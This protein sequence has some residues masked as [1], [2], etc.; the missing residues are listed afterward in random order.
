MRPWSRPHTFWPAAQTATAVIAAGGQKA[1]PA[2]RLQAGP[3][4]GSGRA[5]TLPV[6]VGMPETVAAGTATSASLSPPAVTR[7]SVNMASHSASDALGM[8]GV[9][10]SLARSDGSLAAGRVHVSL[11]YSSFAQAAGGN[12]ASRLHLVELPP[13]ALTTPQLA[14]CRKQTPV[15]SADNVRTTR[16]GADVNLPGLA[17]S[18]TSRG[19]QAA[20]TLA[21]SVSPA[22]LVLAAIASTSGSGGNFAVEPLSEA[23]S[24]VT[25]SSSGA[26]RHSY[27]IQV[28][29]VPGGLEPEVSLDYD[30]QATDG[31]T[32]ST[33]N[34]ASW[35]GDGWDYS[36]GFIQVN[37]P[38]CSTTGVG[39]APG[40]L[41]EGA[42]QISLSL[43]GVTTP[44][45]ESSSGVWKVETDGGGEVLNQGTYWEIIEPD[46]T[47]Y[48][49]GRNKL[50]GYASGNPVTNSLWTVPVFF[51]LACGGQAS[52]CTEPWRY[53]L[54]YVVDPH[55]NAIAYFYNAQTNYYAKGGG[56]T[57]TG[58]YTQG[59]TL[60][61]IEY[62]LRAG[63][64]YG[65]TPAAQVSF[66]TSSTVRADAPT[67]L[68]CASGAACT[69]ISPTFWTSY[70]LTGITT[71][72]LA[73]GSLKNVD[74]WA[75]NG[76]YPATG[77]STTSPSL[78]LSSVT[79]TG[80]DGATAVTPPPVSFAGTPMPNR[81][82]TA[83]DS[84]AGYSQITRFRL[85]SIT[86]ETGAVTT[87]AYSSPDAG[88]CAVTGNFPSPGANTAA[89]YPDYWLLPK[90]SSPI[91][92]WFNVYS[93][94]SVTDRDTTGG[95]P[96]VVTSFSYSGAAWHYDNDTVSR[97]AT[98]TWDQWRGFQSV[99]AKTGTAPDPVTQT[100][101]T[102]LQGMEDDQGGPG[103][104]TLTSSRGDQV[105][106]KDQYAGMVF[107]EITY[108]GAG[109]GNQVT[110]TVDIPYTS[111]ATATNSSLDQAAYITGT[112]S[113]HTYTALA[114][115]GSRESK[116]DYTYNGYGQVLTESDVPD[117]GNAA[118]DRC[119]TITY[120]VN[121]D[122][123]VWLVDLPSEVNVAALPC[124]QTA[125]QP[126]QVISDT[127]YDY[128]GG[129]NGATPAA[130]NL[131]KLLQA[132]AATGGLG[133]SYTYTTETSTYD[134]YGRM[135]TSTDADNRKTTM[136]YT[137][138]TGAEPTSVAVTDPATLLTTTTYDPARDLP[139][140]VTD[141]AGYQSAETYDALGRVT[142]QWTPGNPASGPAV[143]KYAYTVSATAPS[144]TTKQAE[145]PGGGYLTSETLYD[146]LGQVRETQQATVGGGTDVGDTSYNSD[147]WKALVSDPYYTSGA[148]SGT[149]VAA[150]PGSV[151]SQTGYAYDGAGRVTKQ[152]AY[153]LGSETWETDTTYGG[154]YVT[155]V[156][157]PGGTSQTT[158]TDGRGLT[159]A[160]YQY[161]A[162]VPASP[163][164]PSSQYDQTG[165]TYT[166]AQQL[167]SIK[168]AAN[169]SWSYTYDLLGDKLT[170]HD[171][172]AGT[173]TSTYDAAG[174]LMTATDARG[175]QVSNTYDGDGRRTAAYDTTGGAQENTSDQLAAW[176]WDTLAKGQ[177][178][179]S[180]SFSGGA[181]Y[182]EAVTGYNTYE[183][184]SA[185]QTV[186]PAAQGALAGTYTQQDSY[187]PDGQLTSSTDS[188]AGGLPA[189]TVT[190]GY[191][192]AGEASSLTGT[193][194]YVRTLSYTNLGEPL[195][196]TM[197]TSAQPV[198]I[199]DSYDSQTR[200]PAEQKTQTG[201]AQATI[202]DLHYGY[203]NFGHVTSEAD[204]PAAG[205]AD[206]QCFQYDYLGRLVQ[207]WAQGSST[208][209]TTPSTSAEGGTAPYWNAYT[210][211]TVGDLTG[212]TA[213]TPTGA[214]TT[215]TDGY[216]AAGAARPH[217]ITT[218]QV[219]TP[220]GSTSS[221]YGYDASGHLGTITATA[222]NEAFNWNDAGQLTQTAITPSGGTA[223]NTS[224]TYDADGILL[225]T[226]DP[227]T[228]TLY[229]PDEELSLNTGTGTVTGTR[230]YSIGGAT[231]A[232]RTGAST[233][234]Y[235]AGNQQGTDA[236]AI[237][238]G[239]LSVNRRYY[240]PYGN[241]RGAAPP[242]FQ[243]GEK[244]FV[245]G[246]SDT[247]T[248]L[249]N[250]GAREFQ[251]GT[252]SFISPD[253]LL[254]PYDPQNLNAYAYSADN[255]ST[256]SDPSGAMLCDPDGKCGSVQALN[257]YAKAQ[258]GDATPKLKGHIDAN[259]RPKGYSPAPSHPRIGDR[260][261]CEIGRGCAPLRVFLN[262]PD[263]TDLKS[264]PV[265]RTP[266]ARPV[267]NGRDTNSC[268][269]RVMETQIGFMLGGCAGEG[270]TTG[271]NLSK[272]DEEQGE[273]GDTGETGKQGGITP[274]E[275]TK[276]LEDDPGEAGASADEPP[277]LNLVK[278][279]PKYIEEVTGETP[280]DIKADVVGNRG[281]SRYDLYY[282]KNTG[283]LYVL[284]KGGGGE[285]QPTGLRLP[286]L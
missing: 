125:T 51:G 143:D 119:T 224:Y 36:P 150:A 270:V 102:Y 156:P 195:Q 82:E 162:G 62:G 157:P 34:Q 188:A 240:D 8:R 78:W 74:S 18:T 111:T 30:S 272:P 286:R 278:A 218:S 6:W 160:I 100:T 223:K 168:D 211:N 69:V 115:G 47:Q 201:T 192:S 206:V 207:A 29:P 187:A 193:S 67:D 108:N 196:Y 135:L 227:G 155:V 53:M 104:V 171:P 9:V 285:P 48:Y 236:V 255:P 4:A 253:P 204:T 127:Q 252:G 90:S 86:N 117:T 141:P 40:D 54:D 225:L 7:V 52:F 138:A 256:Y 112:S 242:S 43:N 79:R 22:P 251:P 263:E 84:S 109:T 70:A 122:K 265:L 80:Q 14:R 189:E 260:K 205:P 144:V 129:S 121:S 259:P 234:V 26:L 239:T 158:F 179:S 202:D 226:A 152:I 23:D 185:T 261:V 98:Q 12:Y 131:T 101:D 175:K 154:N 151:P 93:V 145:Q 262:R 264:A 246:A 97:S 24:W 163:S 275:V 63:A 76:T 132:K 199:T 32:S 274:G 142:A 222:Q 99:T 71:Q 60:A 241:A 3:S 219:T 200:R 174:Q 85:T 213:T 182:T 209:A 5:G 124:S 178:T 61:K 2:S 130:G 114:G 147:G 25:G 233:L 257:Q 58:Q 21:S 216:P 254:K 31:L 77:D 166:P 258:T 148:P 106:D 16:L 235:L 282:D 64:V 94:A 28:P 96:P 39:P 35:V 116:A 73:N 92:D 164:D 37:Y 203:D 273:T 208:C 197:G 283:D 191:D 113:V 248:G 186:I 228:T 149:L 250:L 167:A 276:G 232:A 269:M 266:P 44:L 81:V 245:G 55:G 126:S 42:G 229:L 215:T 88:A 177:L 11:G 83:A 184:P 59:G 41:C 159:T 19:G 173:T 212:I 221:S 268:P 198:Y 165:Y 110:D 136:A 87:V 50:P 243:A 153:A 66:T 220:S 214:V 267:T 38:A 230:Y 210:Y 194:T 181:A 75:L 146:S 277:A 161:H 169:N 271:I 95:D 134:Q 15:R 120:T 46:G 279:N 49:F 238:S 56:S 33:N 172:D 17:P 128:D 45:V 13:C 217:A 244:G 190:T 281:V 105:D 280:E 10:F 91:K 57:A 170:A 137:P 180:T 247:A 65:V 68:A 183:L 72:S 237:D 176:T 1:R 107:E 27:P 249:T 140:G 231:V 118:E 20:A 123:S 133:L 139:T 89:C 284:R 103:P